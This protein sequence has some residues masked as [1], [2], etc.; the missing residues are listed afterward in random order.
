MFFN[1]WGIIFLSFILASWIFLFTL[2]FGRLIIK[3]IKFSFDFASERVVF[4]SVFGLMA[5]FLVLF[6]IG[7]MQLFNA[8]MILSLFIFGTA[9]L[10]KE[11]LAVLNDFNKLLKIMSLFWRI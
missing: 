5:V 7:L 1:D 8:R 11:C 6:V 9:L 4:A 3:K 10:Y 2:G